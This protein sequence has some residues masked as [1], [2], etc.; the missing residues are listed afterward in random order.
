MSKSIYKTLNW[1]ILPDQNAGKKDF[2]ANTVTEELLLY[3][4][5]EESKFLMESIIPYLQPS[6][7]EAYCDWDS[8]P[9]DLSDDMVVTCLSAGYY[10]EA[11]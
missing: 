6:D 2:I 8:R 1:K 9:F 7:E 3:L 11:A 4:I 10:L 5:M